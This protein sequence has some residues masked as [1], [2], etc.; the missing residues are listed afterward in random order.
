MK[1]FVLACIALAGIFSLVPLVIGAQQTPA[2]QRPELA[3]LYTVDGFSDK[4]PGRVAMP[5]LQ[6]LMAQGAYFR[7]NWTVQTAEPS[8]GV[9][10]SA[11]AQNGYTS[12]IANVTQMSA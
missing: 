6:A 1:R 12:S 9:R 3:I 8:N 2:S 5:N 4:A 7:Q 10:P 11:W